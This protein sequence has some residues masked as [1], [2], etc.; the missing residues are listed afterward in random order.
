MGQ[1]NHTKE[2]LA[3][4]AAAIARHEASQ[5]L[6]NSGAANIYEPTVSYVEQVQRAAAAV[7][8]LCAP[9]P[10]NAAANNPA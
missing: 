3:S 4:V 2:H 9:V 10:I 6:Q 5:S 7:V 1:A 8:T